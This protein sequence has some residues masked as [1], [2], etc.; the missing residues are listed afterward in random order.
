MVL[1]FTRYPNGLIFM[2]HYIAEEQKLPANLQ[3]DNNFEKLHSDMSMGS[4]AELSSS[5]PVCN[6]LKIYLKKIFEKFEKQ[7]FKTKL[8]NNNMRQ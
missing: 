1:N 4:A 7:I 8:V 5:N 2:L 6:S 3:Q